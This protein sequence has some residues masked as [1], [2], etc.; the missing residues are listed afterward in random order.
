[1]AT[2]LRSQ[3]TQG[4]EL[5]FATGVVDKASQQQFAFKFVTWQKADASALQHNFLPLSEWSRLACYRTCRAT[6]AQ[7]TPCGGLQRL[8]QHSVM[9]D[10]L[11]LARQQSGSTCWSQ[12]DRA[13]ST[14]SRAALSRCHGQ[15]PSQ[16]AASSSSAERRRPRRHDLQRVHV[17][18]TAQSSRSSSH[19]STRTEER[20][21]SGTM[22]GG[23]V[24]SWLRTA[25]LQ[26]SKQ[27]SCPVQEADRPL[28]ELACNQEHCAA[29]SE[30][31]ANF[32]PET[33][34][35][36]LFTAIAYSLPC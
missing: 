24:R 8:Q 7:L 1:M 16:A 25:V 30:G 28:G 18:E 3:L 11:L 20:Q 32:S 26:A 33:P 36:R 12:R 4:A 22:S 23:T 13:R 34:A 27:S 6:E 15:I 35:R 19:A 17:A 9:A 14:H 21:E 29:T 31:R 2:C 10:W 5:S